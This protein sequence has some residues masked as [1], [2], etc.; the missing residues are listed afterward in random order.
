MSSK[1]PILPRGEGGGERSSSYSNANN[2]FD[3]NN[4]NG[5]DHD[6]DVRMGPSSNGGVARSNRGNS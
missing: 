3:D 6:G 4:N 1:G 5:D 2:G